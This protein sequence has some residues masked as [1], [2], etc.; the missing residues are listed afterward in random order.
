[1]AGNGSLPARRA[2]STLGPEFLPNDRQ[3]LEKGTVA[4]HIR[5]MPI[6]CTNA[7]CTVSVSIAYNGKLT[8]GGGQCVRAVGHT[9]RAPVRALPGACQCR[10]AGNQVPG[11][12]GLD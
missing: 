10:I 3:G 2:R 8:F 11:A 9:L 5:L 6:E 12:K 4:A 7:L 1:M